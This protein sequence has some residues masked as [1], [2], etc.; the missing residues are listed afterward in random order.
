MTNNFI[1]TNN[2]ILIDNSFFTVFLDFSESAAAVSTTDDLTDAVANSR[3]EEVRS[4]M[5]RKRTN[6]ENSTASTSSAGTLPRYNR[7][8][9]QTVTT[10]S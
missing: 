6:S 7:P 3:L 8:L 4:E 1:L 10:F 9:S 5:R 2:S